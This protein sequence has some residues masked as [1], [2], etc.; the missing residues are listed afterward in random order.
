MLSKENHFCN[1]NYS[2]LSSLYCCALTEYCSMILDNLHLL[3]VY[4]AKAGQSCEIIIVMSKQL[5]PLLITL[6]QYSWAWRWFCCSDRQRRRDA[7][8]PVLIVW[9]LL[10]KAWRL[11]IE[12][13]C[14]FILAKWSC[15]TER[16]RCDSV[17]WSVS[18]AVWIS[19]WSV[20]IARCY[21]CVWAWRFFIL[22][23]FVFAVLIFKKWWI[24][25]A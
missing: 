1:T 22:S 19:V 7:K 9:W 21:L 5:C 4:K 10:A 12:D 6:F 15:W 2:L 25:Y 8:E 16:V 20:V 17:V 11:W 3:T 24:A 14:V 13:W 23:W 18:S